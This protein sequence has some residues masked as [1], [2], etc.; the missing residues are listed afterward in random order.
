MK[1]IIQKIDKKKIKKEKEDM[2][3]KVNDIPQKVE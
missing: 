1:N 2:K 3:D